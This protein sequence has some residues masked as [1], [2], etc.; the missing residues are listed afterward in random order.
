M[1]TGGFDDL[2]PDP[3]HRAVRAQVEKAIQ[4]ADCV[5][6]MVDGRQ[7]LL[8]ADEEI[9]DILRRSRKPVRVA[10]NKVDS[11][12]LEGLTLDFYRFG[13]DSVH[14]LSAAHGYGLRAFLQA[15]VRDLPVVRTRPA[16]A[17]QIR[18][19]VLG[20]PN[21]GKSSL[22]NRLLGS[23]RLLVSERPGTTRD[24]VD[25]LCSFDHQEYLL[26]DTAGIRPRP[27]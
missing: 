12:E 4:E 21:V 1:D 7:G 14:P 17:D 20:K 9:A 25:T 5:I 22:I 6:F 10:V 11:P 13:W 19:A 26:I 27:G 8:P 24:A 18:V 3:L 2:N 23:D 15:L 16:G